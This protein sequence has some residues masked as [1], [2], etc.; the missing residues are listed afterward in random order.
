MAAY[1]H[2]YDQS[3]PHTGATNGLRHAMVRTLAC[4]GVAT[5]EELVSV[6]GDAGQL[7]SCRD[8]NFEMFKKIFPRCHDLSRRNCLSEHA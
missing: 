8:E 7:K 5:K 4:H 6:L 3:K 1:R 2:V